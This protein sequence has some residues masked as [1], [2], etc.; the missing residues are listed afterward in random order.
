MRVGLGPQRFGFFFKPMIEEL[1]WSRS[2]MTGALLARDLVGAAIAPPF[3]FAVDRL[4][5]EVPGGG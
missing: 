3:G 5:T 4:R 2:V 1:G